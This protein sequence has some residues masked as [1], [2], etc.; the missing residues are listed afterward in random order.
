MINDM[1]G[2]EEA[3]IYSLAYSISLIM[4]LFNTA[5]MQTINPWFYQKIKND[6][7]QD[8]ASVAYTTLVM[9]A[10]VNI[11]VIAFAPEAVAIFAPK[12]Y[13]DAIYVI[14]PVAMSVFFMY[15]YDL[16]AKLAFYYE[17]TGFVM[18][19]SVVGAALNVLLNYI[20]IG[21]YGYIAAG[22][23]TLVCYIVYA[24]GHYIF[25]NIVCDQKCG[26]ARPYEL[27]CILRI[28]FGFL[29]IG[30]VF[31]LTYCSIAVRYILILVMFL[32]IIVQKRKIWSMIDRLI[33]K[34]CNGGT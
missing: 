30:F 24:M 8:L 31:G 15:S 11:A 27:K 5:L 12:E 28:S 3:G 10:V 14:P 19:A 7:I 2:V 22:Y 4:T 23:T 18:I 29:L 6:K 1:V 33:E 9:I 13:Y 25:M 17:K 16:F 21:K 34:R 32:I 20:F 26:G